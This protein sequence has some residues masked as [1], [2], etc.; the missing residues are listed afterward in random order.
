[1]VS[2]ERLAK[3]FTPNTHIIKIGLT[4]PG[5][6]ENNRHLVMRGGTGSVTASSQVFPLT[7][8]EYAMLNSFS[9]IKTADKCINLEQYQTFVKRDVKLEEAYRSLYTLACKGY[10]VP[11][12]KNPSTSMNLLQNFSLAKRG[13]L[14]MQRSTKEIGKWNIFDAYG[15]FQV[16]SN[17]SA[18]IP[19][20]V[21]KHDTIRNIAETLYETLGYFGYDRET[22]VDNLMWSALWFGIKASWVHSWSVEPN[23]FHRTSDTPQVALAEKYL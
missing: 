20:I 1:M 22:Q 9:S 6:G 16:I 8:E 2:Q 17:A 4:F 14:F 12:T 7:L 5:D 18:M 10:V 23:Q 3:V 19:D 13:A 21:S 11:F 15:K